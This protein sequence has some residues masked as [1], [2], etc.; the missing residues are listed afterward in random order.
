MAKRGPKRVSKADLAVQVRTMLAEAPGRAVD[1]GELADRLGLKGRARSNVRRLLAQMAGHGEV[2]GAAPTGYRL[3][4]ARELLKGRLVILPSGN[5]FVTPAD[6]SADIFVK[7]GSIGTALPGDTVQVRLKRGRTAQHGTDYR[8]G[9]V[10]SVEERAQSLIVCTLRRSRGRWFAEPLDP[11]YRKELLVRDRKGAG[12]DDRV[13]VRLEHWENPDGFPQG[14]ILEVLGPADDPSIDTRGIIRQYGYAESFPPRVVREAGQILSV[15]RAPGAREDLRDRFVFTIDPSRARDFDDALSLA[16]REGG[17]HTLGVHI[18][19]V[20]HFVRPGGALD[21]EARERG[22]SVYFCDRVLPMLPEQVSNGICSLRPNEDRLAFSVFLDCSPDGRI[23]GRRFARTIIRSRARLT[24]EQ[25]MTV[26]E[27]G[28][29]D[30]CPD[31]GLDRD[32][33][34]VL[35]AIH[36]L[37]Q[38]LR[39]RRFADNALELDMPE[40]E[41][42]MG[43]GHMIVDVCEVHNDLSHQLIEE[44]MIA[45]NEAVDRELGDRGVPLLHRIHEAPSPNR[46]GELAAQLQEMGFRTGNLARPENLARFLRKLEGHPLANEAKIAVLRSMKRALYSP[47]PV[48]H[49]GLGKSH[50]AHFTSP[51]RRYPDL[52]VHRILG[53][54]LAGESSPYGLADLARLGTHCSR[55]EKMADES[56]K[57]L[58]EIKKYRFLEQQ[59]RARDPQTYEAVVVNVRRFGLFVEIIH[60][61]VQGLLHVSN[62]GGKRSRY[63]AGAETLRVGKTLFKTGMTLEVFP[64][65]VDLEKRKLDFGLA[66]S[67]GA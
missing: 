55:T 44:C 25:A 54:V 36:L 52:V 20:S 38:Q 24:Y 37:A 42:R 4:L 6:G 1:A 21:E 63:S 56:E 17:G 62:L 51:I 15:P 46:V 14:E 11:R 16:R 19:D 7:R 60:L 5:G 28:G 49:F 29:T 50:Y 22:T 9:V 30:G 35:H 59:I 13:V 26:I 67:P 23:V 18:A 43:G 58:L 47:E 3:G 65:G 61:G 2:E 8:A 27:S 39:A 12:Q 33:A 45:V 40:F 34:R 57:L 31:A 10:V 64:V 41:I 53:G 66:C 32:G 48:G